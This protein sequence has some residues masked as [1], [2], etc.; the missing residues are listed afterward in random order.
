M[1]PGEIHKKRGAVLKAPLQVR[2]IVS[3]RKGEVLCKSG[4]DS[5]CRHGPAEKSRRWLSFSQ[6]KAKPGYT[7]APATASPSARS[8]IFTPPAVRLRMEMSSTGVIIA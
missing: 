4:L 8:M 7:A 5:A 6:V 1:P 3:G 2:Q